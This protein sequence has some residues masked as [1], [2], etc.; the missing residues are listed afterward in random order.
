MSTARAARVSLALALAVASAVGLAG[1]VS[2]A[3]SRQASVV[4][5]LQGCADLKG[6]LVP[7]RRIGL[8]TT[9]GLVTDAVVVPASAATGTASVGEFC[10]VS[11]SLR[12]VDPTAP[13]IRLQVALPS[14]W[15]SKSV[16]FGGGGYNGT[17][18]AVTGNVPFG[19]G[20][21]LTP[22]G[23]GY[24][25]YA[26]DSGHQATPGFTPTPSLDGSFLSND[27]ALRNFAGDALKKTHDAATF[28]VG[29]YYGTRTQQRY[30]AGGSTG[31][32]E[33]LAVAQR[34]PRDFSGVLSVYPAFNA[35]ALDL[36]FGYMTQQFAKP[37]A[38][39]R[40][41]QQTLLYNA[42]IAAC[43][44]TDGVTDGVIGDEAA[45]TFDPGVL[46][47]PAGAETADTCLTEAQI[48]ALRAL[49]RPLRFPY[50][51]AGKETGYP[52]F[53][54]LSGANLTTPLLG[55]GS[56]APASPMPKTAAYGLQFWDQWVRFAVT[57]DPSFNSLTLDPSAPDAY[58]ER[59]SDLTALQEVNR[60]DLRPFARS[61]GKLLLL[62]GTADELVS[63]RSTVDYY[64]RLVRTM[65]ARQVRAF[66]RFYLV[67]G[68]NHANVTP[69]FA[70]GWD[71]LTAL[72]R[73]ATTGAPPSNPV[74]TDRR[75]GGSRTRPLCEYPDYPRYLGTGSAD[76]ASSFTCVRSDALV[77]AARTLRFGGR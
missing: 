38:F 16:M 35:A 64:N 71:S 12:P 17:I 43:D 41:A 10:R 72:D 29:E 53:P 37:G 33:A 24:V 54:Y 13:E 57:R 74:V 4:E 26:S 21:E 50:P 49:S 46:L 20:D 69:A 36:F 34:F 59:I 9:G 70:A 76:F 40:P 7:A 75:P 58:Q 55:I 2:A 30:F 60:S 44:D 14:R 62:H 3:P 8:P 51:T 39:P 56:S 61:G 67:P 6:E 15:N 32:R 66:T 63:H 25:T 1:P 77:Q 19:P 31:G 22:L 27:E 42:A 65:G 68:A 52:G 48:E 73:W 28:I 5:P 23:R 45:C 18:P 47:C 11:A